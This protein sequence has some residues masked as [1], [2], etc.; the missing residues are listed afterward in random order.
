MKVDYTDILSDSDRLKRRIGHTMKDMKRN[1][2]EL[3]VRFSWVDVMLI[4]LGMVGAGL[5]VGGIKKIKKKMC[6]D[7]CMAR[8]QNME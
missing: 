8:Y 5:S 6:C 3:S 1:N 2:L 4:L 7:K